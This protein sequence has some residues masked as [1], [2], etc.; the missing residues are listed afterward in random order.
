MQLASISIQNASCV[1]TVASCLETIHSS[2]KMDCLI[3]RMVSRDL[4]V[5]INS[6]T[7]VNRRDKLCYNTLKFYLN[8]LYY[9][10]LEITVSLTVTCLHKLCQLYVSVRCTGRVC[11]TTW[12]VHVRACVHTCTYTHLCEVRHCIIQLRS[13]VS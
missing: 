11:L 10:L 5:I 3:V 9:L 8:S 7:E 6:F 2:W 4:L 13:M 12:F 1:L